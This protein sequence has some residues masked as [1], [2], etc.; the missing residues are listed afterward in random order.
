MPSKFYQTAQT[1]LCNL[2]LCLTTEQYNLV[3]NGPKHVWNI[4]RI[5]VKVPTFSEGHKILRNLNLTSVLCSAS[6]IL[7]PSQKIWTLPDYYTIPYASLFFTWLWRWLNLR[8][9]FTLAKISNQN[10]ATSLPWVFS[11]FCDL[12]P[13]NGDLS[14]WKTFWD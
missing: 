1:L 8:K 12:A 9:F 13:F 10:G 2:I 3:H 7:W 6:Q 4:I 11:F 5:Y 14:Q